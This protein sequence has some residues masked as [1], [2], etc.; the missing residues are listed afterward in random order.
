MSNDLVEAILEMR[1]MIKKHNIITLE[2]VYE[3]EFDEDDTG[4]EE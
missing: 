4:E 1:N 3:I 2:D